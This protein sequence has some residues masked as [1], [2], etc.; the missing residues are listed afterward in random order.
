MSNLSKQVELMRP[1]KDI[2]I[3]YFMLNP[4]DK[5]SMYSATSHIPLIAIYTFLL[6]DFPEHKEL[7][8]KKIKE[9]EDFYGIG[10]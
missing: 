6:E 7:C 10:L 2:I 8:D 5:V 3:K 9:L 4:V 1:Q